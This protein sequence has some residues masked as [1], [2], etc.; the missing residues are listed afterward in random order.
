MTVAFS[1][2]LEILIALVEDIG[3]VDTLG[4]NGTRLKINGW[5]IGSSAEIVEIR[6][7]HLVCGHCDSLEVIHHRNLM[8]ALSVKC[9]RS[10]VIVETLGCPKLR[11]MSGMTAPVLD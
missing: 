2:C 1:G 9:A 11:K 4:L 3:Q 8:I 7:T 6:F 5:R 10:L